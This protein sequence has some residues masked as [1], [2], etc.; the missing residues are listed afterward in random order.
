[1]K[2][3]VSLFLLLVRPWPNYSVGF[4]PSAFTEDQRKK[5]QPYI[6]SFTDT[7]FFVATWRMWFPFFTCEVKCGAGTL[8]VADRQNAHSATL[9]VSG[10]AVSRREAGEAAAPRNPRLLNL[11]RQQ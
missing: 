7:S 4:A 11:A 2:A 8:D 9:A 6:D 5:L 10:G 1:M 3:G